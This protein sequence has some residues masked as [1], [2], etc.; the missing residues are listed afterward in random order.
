MVA[1]VS[2]ATKQLDSM[3]ANVVNQ[4]IAAEKQMRLVKLQAQR[5]AL[6][7][8][9]AVYTDLQNYIQNLQTSTQKWSSGHDSYALGVSQK[10]TVSNAPDGI[11]FLSATTTDEATA[12]EYEIEVLNLAQNHRVSSDRQTST[13]Y[14]VGASGTFTIN[15]V[16]ITVDSADSLM[17][18]AGKINEASFKEG[19]VVVL[20]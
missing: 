9:N 14:A 8:K 12:A 18:I 16:D 2:N 11:N 7:V 3:F 20:L 13:N 1:S 5:D 10:A 4:T 19:K 17:T 15:D 6:D